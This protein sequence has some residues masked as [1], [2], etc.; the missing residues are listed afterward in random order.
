MTE[1]YPT[2]PLGPLS[3]IYQVVDEAPEAKPQ[4]ESKLSSVKDDRMDA[5]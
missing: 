5:L 3:C 2:G 4:A 1:S